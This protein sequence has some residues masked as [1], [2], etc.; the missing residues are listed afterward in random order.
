MPLNSPLV[1]DKGS[2]ALA[3]GPASREYTSRKVT[4]LCTGTGFFC[5]V[6]YFKYNAISVP[7]FCG[8]PFSGMMTVSSF[9]N[10][11]PGL[12]QFPF[13]CGS[14]YSGGPVFLGLVV[15]VQVRRH[16]APGSRC[17]AVRRPGVR[18]GLGNSS[19]WFSSVWMSGSS[20]LLG[21]CVFTG[22]PLRAAGRTAS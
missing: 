19:L 8:C 3:R 12:H 1:L 21:T 5:S 7:T 9:K 22:L 6:P 17:L 10:N 11:Q 14:G 13:S 18:S 15:L 16:G 4:S 20:A 2:L